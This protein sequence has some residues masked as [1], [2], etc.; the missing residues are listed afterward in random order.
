M[1]TLSFRN[2][3]QGLRAIAVLS[4]IAFHFNPLILPGGFV[5]VDV[6][7]VISGYLICQILIQKKR[8]ANS[9]VTKIVCGFLIGRFKRI[10][11]AY[12]FMLGVVFL[13]SSMLLL[14][15]DFVLLKS[16]L[17][18]A[19]YFDSN[20]YFADFRSYFAPANSEQIILHTW[21]LSVEA[22]FYLIIPFFILLTPASLQNK[23]LITLIIGLC[24]V[25]QYRLQVLGL[26]QATYYSLWARLPEFFVGALAGVI[27]LNKDKVLSSGLYIFGV[28]ALI[29]SIIYQ[30][31]L[32]VFPG[33]NAL[34]PLTGVALLL[35]TQPS[36]PHHLASYV[37]AFISSQP[38]C[39]LGAISY[40]LYLWH[41][42]VLAIL[43]YYSGVE[44]L[45]LELSVAF[46]VLTLSLSVCSYYWIE[47]PLRS[48]MSSPLSI[49]NRFWIG[50]VGIAIM[51]GVSCLI[52]GRVNQYFSLPTLNAIYTDYAD[53][54]KICHSQIIGDCLQ[55]DLTSSKELLVLGD[56]HAAMLN[57]FFDELGRDLE[58]KARVVSSSSCMTIPGFDYFRIA[59]GDRKNCLEQI[60]Q[61][62]LY[63]STA[64]SVVLAGRWESHLKSKEF[65][66][67]L[68]NF[69][70]SQLKAGKT[71]YLMAQIPRPSQNP[72]RYQRHNEFF[73]ASEISAYKIRENEILKEFAT[74]WPNIKYLDFSNSEFFYNAPFYQGMPIYMDNNH[75]N[76]FGAVQYGIVAKDKFRM[77]LNNN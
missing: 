36:L 23:L 13:V 65:L 11:P 38:L 57:H 74:K 41:W 18:K 9:G 16:S 19:L 70:D 37:S 12:M 76:L 53:P 55:G 1:S 5:G 6:F 56:S 63:I 49:K 48:S 75:L 33:V 8:A 64:D 77:M 15:D 47:L 60:K 66:K 20:K 67:A 25:S 59:E 24:L 30:P 2:D 7:F 69:F 46:I 50:H 28:V 29:L 45:S 27:G 52:G 4:V 44:I 62:Q 34:L 43:R 61:A 21:S 58:F 42:P 68:Q 39:W 22:Q 32:G 3:I 73:A 31:K 10:I 51:V 72:Y 40:S 17:T 35:T 71:V 54:S 14:P 26:E